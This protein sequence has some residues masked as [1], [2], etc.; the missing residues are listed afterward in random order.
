MGYETCIAVSYKSLS[1]AN[2]ANGADDLTVTTLTARII[3]GQIPVSHLQIWYTW[4]VFL[5]D[6]SNILSYLQRDN[7][8]LNIAITVKWPRFSDYLGIW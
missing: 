7:C 4:D 5:V 8:Q 1:D 6:V 3:Y 2:K